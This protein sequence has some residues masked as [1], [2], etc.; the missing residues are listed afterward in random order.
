MTGGTIGMSCC[1]SSCMHIAHVF[2]SLPHHR[3][4]Q[5]N[6]TGDSDG[7]PCGSGPNGPQI[8]KCDRPETIVPTQAWVLA[9]EVVNR[10]SSSSSKQLCSHPLISYSGDATKTAAPGIRPSLPSKEEK[11]QTWIHFRGG[12]ERMGPRPP[13][14]VPLLKS[15][16]SSIL[17]TSLSSKT[18]NNT[19]SLGLGGTNT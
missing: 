13:P 10:L 12:P 17:S 9:T 16:G 11:W 4:Y 7:L 18:V 6:R 1:L 3:P 15:Y 8:M 5:T 19:S 2:T 14:W